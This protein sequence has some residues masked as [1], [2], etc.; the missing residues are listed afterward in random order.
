[1]CPTCRTIVQLMK[2]VD[3]IFCLKVGKLTTL[4]VVSFQ[5]KMYFHL[6]DIKLSSGLIKCINLLIIIILIDVD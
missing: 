6:I 5:H 2:S 3:L 4:T 1:M